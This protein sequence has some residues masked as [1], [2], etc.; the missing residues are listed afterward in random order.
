MRFT[1]LLIIGDRLCNRRVG[2]CY[3]P[4]GGKY[5]G[6][7]ACYNLTYRSC[8]EHDKR[9]DALMKNPELL[10]AQMKG[11]DL[12]GSRLDLKAHAKMMRWI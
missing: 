1:C 5:F 8:K 3:L 2:K 4:P 11:D 10:M 6:C 7:R 9:I 12:K